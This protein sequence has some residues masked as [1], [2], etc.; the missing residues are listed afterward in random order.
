MAIDERIG[1]VKLQ[2]H[3]YKEATNISTLLSDKTNLYEY[4]HRR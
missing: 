2:Y 3:V 4:L 1:D